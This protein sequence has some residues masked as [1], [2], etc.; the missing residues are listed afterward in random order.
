LLVSFAIYPAYPLLLFLPISAWQKGGVGIALAAVSWG[1]F[2]AGSAL[3]GKKGVAYLK[4]R[5]FWHREHPSVPENLT[6]GRLE[7]IAM[8]PPS[9]LYEGLLVGF[10]GAAAV[11][12]W[13]F[14]LDLATAIPF[15]TPALL[16]AVLFDGLQDPAALTI[17][18]GLVLKYTAVHGV[19][20]L[21]F[22]FAVAG[23]FALAERDRHL[24]IGV[25]TL[26][27]CF[28]VAVVAAMLVLGSWLLDTLQPWAILGGN[29]VAALV[30][31]GVLFRDHHFSLQ[32]LRTSG[33]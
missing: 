10:A 33:E 15:R 11:A 3:V 8:K 2:F 31:L 25:F 32:E 4:H 30:M 12:M 13:F 21:I 6:T 22:G 14:V 24:L 16:G 20:F 18:V 9:V 5:L 1:I 7:E 23:L 27:C 26:F 17:T 19:A 29:L 28:E